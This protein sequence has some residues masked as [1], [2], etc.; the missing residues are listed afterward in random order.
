MTTG[1]NLIKEREM[2]AELGIAPVK[3]WPAK[4]TWYRPNGT[5]L[6][7]LPCDPYSRMLYMGRGFRPDISVASQDTQTEP[8]VTVTLLDALVALVDDAGILEC[9]A[10][11]LLT[12]LHGVADELPQDT[13]RLSKDLTGLASQLAARGIVLER[14]KTS[15]GTSNQTAKTLKLLC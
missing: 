11:E 13:T 8:S 9:T 4:C 7:N 1:T 15:N 5:V 6:G 14:V 12:K 10:T 2:L 3:I